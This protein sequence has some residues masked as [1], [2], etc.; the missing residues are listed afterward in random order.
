[1]RGTCDLRLILTVAALGL[2][3]LLPAS[4]AGQ[5]PQT[6]QAP[7]CRA[8]CRG[9]GLDKVKAGDEHCGLVPRER[10]RA[11]LD[12]ACTLADGQRE[13]LRARARERA[14]GKCGD[15]GKREGCRCRGEHRRWENVYT[16]HLSGRCWTECGWAY[17]LE[18]E[19]EPEPPAE[20]G[21]DASALS[22]S[23]SSRRMPASL[24]ATRRVVG[25]LGPRL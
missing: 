3:L 11:A 21:D 23:P 9:L 20:T 18:C 19:R 22:V 16:N 2:L 8:K 4:A 6:T 15:A 25:W 12:A 14:E 24:T 10:K 5:E 17:L 13:E 1:M 7:S